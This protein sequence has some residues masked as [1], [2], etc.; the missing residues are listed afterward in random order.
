M[1]LNNKIS[2]IEKNEDMF[3]SF[4]ELAFPLEEEIS[5][6]ES[7]NGEHNIEDATIRANNARIAQLKAELELIYDKMD[8]IQLSS[9][10]SGMLYGLMHSKIVGPNHGIYTPYHVIYSALELQ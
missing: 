3:Q 2:T 1:E 8:Q 5:I 6:L 10:S 9:G 4:S 7:E